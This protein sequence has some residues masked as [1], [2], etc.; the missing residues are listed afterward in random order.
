M[1]SRTD[2]FGL[3]VTFL[4]HSDVPKGKLLILDLTGKQLHTKIVGNLHVSI[5]Y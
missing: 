2:N 5:V 1:Y 3:F 4:I